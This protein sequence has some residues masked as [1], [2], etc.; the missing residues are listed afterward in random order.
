LP[1]ADS[2]S[3]AFPGRDRLLAFFVEVSDAIS[4]HVAD[5]DTLLESVARL[6]RKLLDYEIL[7]FLLMDEEETL[8][9]RYAVG[10][11]DEV[12]RRARIRLG[13]GITGAAALEQKTIVV[14]DVTKD[15]RYINAL[16]SVRSE[17][18]VPLLAR[19]KTVGVLDLQ[20]TV[21]GAFTDYERQMI[22]LIA[23]RISLAVD[24]A[25]LF[26]ELARSRQRLKDDLAAARRI[27]RDLLLPACP[28]FEGIEIAAQN[29]P[30]LEV[31]GDF[32]DFYT[33]EG[34]RLGVVLGD[35][36]GK[37]AAAALYG[38]LTS[39]LLRSLT[40]YKQSPSELLAEV[41]HSLTERQSDPRTFATVGYLKWDPAARELAYA[42]SGLPFP[43]LA[44]GGRVRPLE[45]AGIPLGM[46]R[47]TRYEE[48]RLPL[49]RG[50]LLV[51]VSDGVLDSEDPGERP[52]DPARLAELIEHSQSLP[53][54]EIVARILAD[55]ERHSAGKRLTDDQT[56]VVLKIG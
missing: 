19:G 50:D 52:Y 11:P 18:A 17:L 51:L 3:T 21:L 5:L 24:N 2:A 1:T 20:S 28:R 25:R 54:Q 49:G 30:V 27:Q 32:Y 33:F 55:L 16:D 34:A 38:A 53:A 6:M 13:E 9:I 35:V 39:G 48:V 23:S 10:L 14:N 8:R 41:N 22:E 45:V 31:S 36:S 12:V 56:L 7:V 44:Q 40:R 37:G 15:P 42:S 4:A 29:R 43:L 47:G 26:E 46:F